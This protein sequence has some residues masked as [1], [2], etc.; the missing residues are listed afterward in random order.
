MFIGHFGGGF[1]AKTAASNTSLGTLFFAAQFLDLLWPTL[2]LLGIEDVEIK[3]GITRSNP[4]NFTNYP[5]SHSLLIVCVWSLLFGVMH[6]LFQRNKRTAVVL[7]I[8]VL[9][10]WLLD[11]IVH[12]PD[13]PLY[14]GNSPRVGLGLWNSVPGTLLVEGIIF[15]VGLVLY[16]RVTR[17]KNRIGSYG[18]WALAAFLVLVH[19]ANAF[20]PTPPNKHAIAWVGQLQWLLIIWGSWIDRNRIS[21]SPATVL[22]FHRDTDLSESQ[23]QARSKTLGGYLP[24]KA[25]REK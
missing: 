12:R 6:W 8:C 10:H 19:L 4:L 14:P 9:S 23:Y 21:L 16:L 20:G 15:T 11:V 1:G 25:E 17:A 13:L 5:I 2:L 7:G 3:P 18:F 24:P 22:S